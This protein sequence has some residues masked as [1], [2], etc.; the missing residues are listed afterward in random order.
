MSLLRFSLLILFTIFTLGL[1]YEDCGYQSHLDDCPG[2]AYDRMNNIQYRLSSINLHG[3]SWS[4][5]RMSL[6]DIC[7]LKNNTM[8][9]THCFADWTH[10]DC[11]SIVTIHSFVTN[12]HSHVTGMHPIN[13]LGPH[14]TQNSILVGNDNNGSWCTCHHGAPKDVCHLQFGAMLAFKLIWCPNPSFTDFIALF[15][16]NDG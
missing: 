16:D 4:K 8:A 15:V 5:L 11:C 3:M 12:Q 14:I 10:V 13:Q 7:G 2:T 1:R 6:V 9:T